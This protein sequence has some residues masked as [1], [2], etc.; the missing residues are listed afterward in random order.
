MEINLISIFAV[1]VLL[2][3]AE[4]FY[5]KLAERF[6][7]I[8]KPNARSS[9]EHPIIRGG[10]IIFLFSVLFWFIQSKFNW[11]WFTFSILLIATISFLDDISSVKPILRFLVQLFSVLLIFYQQW[12]IDWSWFMLLF[13]LIIFI[14]T[15]N[16]FN[17]MD[18]INGITGIYALVTLITFVFIHGWVVHFTDTHLLLFVLTSVVIFLFFNFRKTARCFAGDV[19]SVTIALILIFVMIQLMVA[20]H[21]FFWI[22]LFLVYGIDSI[23]TI[24]Y[25]LMRKENIFKAHRTHLF[26]YLSNE[27]KLPQLVVSC[28]YA[29][30]QAFF[31]GILIWGFTQHNRF[32]PIIVVLA[33]GITYLILRYRVLV[34][35]KTQNLSHVS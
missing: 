35:I 8:D 18:G 22:F 10:G 2:L 6:K 17:F 12:P 30:S 24:V 13:L 9:H 19:G 29:L 5:F 34:K 4:L 11:P 1:T 21:S 31:N 14:G 28:C 25:R 15:M 7:I 20:T 16:A 32:V 27:M 23:V 26:Q 33:Y 3:A